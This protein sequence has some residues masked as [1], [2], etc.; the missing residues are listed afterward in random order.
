MPARPGRTSGSSRRVRSARCIVDPREPECR[1]RRRAGSCLWRESRIAACTARATAARRG[2]RC[3]SRA[4]TSARSTSPSIRATR[5]SIYAALWNTRRPPW[6]IYPP[7]YGP[8]SGLYKS[9]DG[10]ANWQQ[11]TSGLPTEGLGRIGIA[12]APTN[13]PP[14]LRDRRR[15]GRRAVPVGRRRRDVAKASSDS[16]IWGRGWY[17]GKIAVDPKNADIVY[18]LEH[19]RVSIAGRRPDVR[20]AV[21]GIAGRRRLSPAVDFPGRRQPD[22]PRR[23]P[24]RR[25]Q[26]RRPE[27]SS[28]LELVA[29]SADRAGLP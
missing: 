8:G 10:G 28:D 22:D 19:R 16:R 27:R 9:T 25:D 3:C 4:T 5:R 2:R 13:R 12:V 18:V 21:Q 20:R 6:S 14:R 29:E 7:S 11:L 23:R 17:F 26:R 1:V 24:G 15:Q